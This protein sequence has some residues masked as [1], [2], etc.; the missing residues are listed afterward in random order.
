MATAIPRPTVR[1]Y[2]LLIFTQG[3]SALPSA[4][5]ERCQ[6]WVSPFRAV[7]TSLAQKCHSGGKASNQGPQKPA[8]CFPLLW[9]SRYPSCKRSPLLFS[10]F[11]SSRSIFPQPP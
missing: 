5:G 3:P 2:L 4:C 8:W 11:S 1:Y 10:L 6:A 9:L 7:G